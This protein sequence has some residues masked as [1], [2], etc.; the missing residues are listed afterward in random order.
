M[1]VLALLGSGRSGSFGLIV[2]IGFLALQVLMRRGR[3]GGRGGPF[4]GG[5]FGGGGFGGGRGGP[6]GGGGRGPYGGGGNGGSSG[7]GTGS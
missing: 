7:G 2:I 3:G 1:S 4:G 6:F 5:G